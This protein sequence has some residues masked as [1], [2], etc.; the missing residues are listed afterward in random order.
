M[1][2]E[3]GI[4]DDGALAQALKA[5]TIAAAGLGVFENE[6]VVNPELLR[7]PNLVMTPHTGSATARY[8]RISQP[9]ICLRRSALVRTLATLRPSSI[10]MC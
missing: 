1:L 9:T 6:P 2:L 3:C 10:L 5:G 4:V 7:A 8:A